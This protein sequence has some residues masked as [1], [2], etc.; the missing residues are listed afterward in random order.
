MFV[1][2]IEFIVLENYDD[3]FFDMVWFF[4]IHPFLLLATEN[5]K[6]AYQNDNYI[7]MIK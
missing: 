6:V 4:I 3:A 1:T 5:E 7:T 2:S